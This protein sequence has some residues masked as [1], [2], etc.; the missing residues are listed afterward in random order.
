MFGVNVKGIFFTV[1][2]SLPKKNEGGS[3]VLTGCLAKYIGVGGLSVY[4][5]TEELLCGHSAR[6]IIAD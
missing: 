1:Q 5:A 6:S 4:G 2:K 3:I